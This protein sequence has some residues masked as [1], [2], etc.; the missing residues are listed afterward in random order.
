[1]TKE[2]YFELCE[3]LGSAPK[4]DEIPLEYGDFPSE[5]HTAFVVYDMLKDDWDYFNGNYFGKN[6]VGITEVFNILDI[7]KQDWKTIYDIV[8]VIDSVKTKL[9]QAKKKSS[10]NIKKPLK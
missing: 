10:E 7:P 3:A 5:V 1:M 9:I 8:A 2:A 6:F 4:A